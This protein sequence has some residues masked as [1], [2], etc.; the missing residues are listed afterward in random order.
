MKTPTIK[1][2]P[3][4]ELEKLKA[5]H[6]KSQAIGEFVDL[7]MRGNGFTFGKPHVHDES[8]PGWDHERGKYNPGLGDGC[9]FHSG[10]MI[11][12]NTPLE[13]LLAEF[14]NIDMDK[15]E[16]ERRA[17]LDYMRRKN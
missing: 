1:Y 4:P 13:K 11:H 14:F 12:C 2:P 5:V 15:V 3:T 9:S 8:C 10:D 16:E 6:E 7:F 17:I